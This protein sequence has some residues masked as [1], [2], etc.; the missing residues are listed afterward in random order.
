MFDLVTDSLTRL[1][2]R[3]QKIP[4][5]C[6]GS[7]QPRLQIRSI[8]SY[9]SQLVPLVD[10]SGLSDQTAV[11]Q[12]QAIHARTIF[13]CQD[14]PDVKSTYEFNLRSHLP[15]I[16]SGLFTGTKDFQPGKAGRPGTLL[17]TFKQDI[18]IPS[19]LFAIASG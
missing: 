16:A 11:S 9:V 3:L 5:H 12:C 10:V 18:P 4:L 8:R 17:Y 7:P 13:P 14:T 15:V 6:S 2:C 1:N 19:Y